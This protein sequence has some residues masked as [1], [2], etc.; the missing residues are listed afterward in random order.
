[1]KTTFTAQ[2]NAASTLNG[3]HAAHNVYSP[4]RRLTLL[5]TLLMTFAL[6]ARAQ[7]YYVFLNGSGYY[8][9]NNNGS[10]RATTTFS[11]SCVWIASGTLGNTSRSLQSY[12]DNSDY[13]RGSTNS[14]SIGNSQSNWR[15]DNDYLR[16]RQSSSNQRYIGYQNNNFTFTSNNS[17]SRDFRAYSVTIT[18]N[19]GSEEI[20]FSVPSVTINPTSADIMVPE[21]VTFTATAT[22]SVTQTTSTQKAY[23]TFR[24]NNKDYLYEGTS[25]EGFGQSLTAAP[26]KATTTKEFALQGYNY[27]LSDNLKSCLEGSSTTNSITYASKNPEE[28]VVTGSITVTPNYGNNEFNVPSATATITVRKKLDNPTGIT[29]EDLTLAVDE[30]KSISY[31]LTPSNAYDNI[32]YSGNYNGIISID[33]NGVVKGLKAGITTVTLTAKNLNGT[34]SAHSA[35]ST[36]TVTPKAPTIEFS[37]GA[38]I[39]ATIS[40]TETGATIYYTTDGTTPTTS[41]PEYTAPVSVTAGATVKAIVVV[42]ANG[43]PLT[44]PVAE[45]LA[46]A[47]SGIV[48][49]TVFLYDLE[50]H[51]WTYYSG[52]DASVDGGNYNTNYAGKLYSPNPRNVKITYNANGGA[53]SIDESETSFVYF[54]T[55]EQGATA[56]QYPYTV[57]S[58]PFSK[59]PTGKGFGGWKIISGG[60]YINGYNNGSTLPLDQE[61]TFVNLPYPSTNCISAEIELEATWVDLNNI[62]RRT[63][64]GDYTY[65]ATGGT[66][67]TNIL[68]LK[69]NHTGTITVNSPCTIMMVEPDGTDNF[70][71]DYT[72]SGYIVPMAN[73]NTKIEFARWRPGYEGINPRGRNFTIGRGM[74]MDGTRR[75][76]YGTDQR[77]AMNQIL[78]V[79]SGNF[80][81]FTS[82]NDNPTSITKHWVVFGCDYDRAKNDNNR[83][84]F[85]GE[86]ITG[87]GRTLGL[88][89]KGEMARVWSK[90][91][92][93]MTGVQ[94]ADAAAD[95]SY[96]VGV[97]TNH[98]NGHRY[99]E[100]QGGEWY[101]NIA[102]GMGEDHTATDPGFTFRMKG[103]IIRGSVYGAAAFAGAGG[104]RTYVITG[105]TIGGWVAGGANGTQSSGGLL[106]GTTYIY[107]GGKARVDSKGS[108]NV[109]NRAVGG[110]VFGAGCG[111]GTGSDSGEIS[112]GTNVVIADEA[113]IERGV[114]GGGSY[115]FTEA[116][117]NL[118]ITGGRIGG[119]AGGV[120]GTSY[121]ANIPGGVYGGACQNRGGTVNIYMTDGEVNGGLYGGSNNSGTI[122]NNVTMKI[123]GGQVGTSSKSA[124]IHGGGY[125]QSTIVTGNVNLSLGTSDQTSEGVTVW[126]DVYGG[127]ALGKVNCTVNNYNNYQYTNNTETNVTLYKGTING[128]LYGGALGGSNVGTHVYGPV[129]VKVY[130]G[131]VKKTSA[132]GSGGVYGAN[133]KDGAPQRSVTV[134]IYG[135]DPAPAE[136]Q[137]ALHAVY[138][139]GNQAP[140]TYGNGYPKVTVHNCDNSIEYVYGGGNAAAVAATDVTIWGGDVIG[141]VFGGGNGT[142]SAADVNGDATTKIYGGTILN[143]YGGSNS[144]GTIGGTINVTVNSQAEN[145]GDA[146]CTMNIGSVYGGGNL[147]ASNVGNL[148]ITCTGT[149]GRIDNV[150]GGANQANITGDID[151]KING[152]NI[153]NVFGGNNIKGDISGTI[154]VTVGDAPNDCG[155]FKVD[156]VY[157][158]GNLAPYGSA[159]GTKG[160]YPVVNIYSGTV[161]NNVFG[162]GLG[163]SAIVYGNPQVTIGD[164]VDEHIAIVGGDVY[165]GGDA[166]NVVG[167]PVVKIINDCNTTI[168]NVYGGGNAADVNGTDVN[169]DG[170]TITGMV[171][172]GGHGDK[173]ADPQTEAN[174]NGDVNVDITGGTINKVFGG[175]NSKGNITGTIALNIEKGDESCEIHIT[176]VYGGGNEAAGNAGTITI[177]CTGSETEGI[178]D[179]YGGANA[180]DINTPI[181][182][183][184]T[185]GNISRVFGGNNTSGSINGDIQVNVDWTE[186]CGVNALGNVYGAGNQAAYSGNTEV[187]ILNG[188]V[189]GSVYG[190]GL[191]ATAVVTG[192][193]TVNID[194]SAE[195][196]SVAV[197]QNVLGGGDAAAVEGSTDVNII[198]GAIS[199]SVFGGGN[200]AGVSENGVVDVTGGT[201][202]S[203]V[204]GGSNASGTVGNTTVALADGIIGTD[205]A[206]ANVH[207]GGYGKETKVSGNVAVNIQGGTIYGDIYGGSALGTVNTNPSNTTAVNL[208]GGLVHGDAYGGGLGDSDTA[209]DVNGNVTVTLDG[210]AFTLATTTDDKGNTIPTSGRVFGCNN[211]NG[212]PKGTVL[213]KVLNTVARDGEGNVKAK[214]TP[215][216]GVYELQ[217]V[218]GGGNL[219][220]YNPTDPAADGQ[221]TSYTYGGNTVA[222]DNID[223]PVQVVIDGCDETSIEYVYG[224]G[225]AAATPATD[226]TVL[227]SYEIGSVFGGGNGK[228]K[229]TLDRGTTWNAN[230]GADVGIINATAYKADNSQGKYGTGDA[231]TS[232]LG[233]TVHNIYGGS[234]TL[235]NIVGDATAYLDAASDCELNIDGIYGGGNEAYMD[236]NSGIQLGCITYLKEIYG[237]ARNADVGGDINLTITSGH[238]DRVFGGNN[239]GGLVKGSITV[240]IEETGCNPITIGELY[241]CGNKAAYTTPGDRHPT[242]NI[243]SF[244]SIGNVFG[245]G[246]GEEAV[247]TGNPTVNINVAKG[248]NNAVEGWPYNGNTI[249]FDDGST[250]TLPVHEEGKIGAIGNVFGGGNAAAVIG[251][252]QVNIG[253]EASVVFE[254]L[255]GAERTKTVEGA[256]IRGNVYGGG[257]QA[258]VTGKTNVV[259][260]R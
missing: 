122:S 133:N 219:A 121:S 233:G 1:M 155:V 91:G 93:F 204:Y 141:N 240:N 24:F 227:G 57:I 251:N 56:G 49:N 230:N 124:N 53:V 86:F 28:E 4:L 258:K 63:N 211:I 70:R 197:T 131:S 139:G 148:I 238:F 11:P 50:D 65:S 29:A 14:L 232:V 95:N 72:F 154:S 17:S 182:L 92:S 61:I 110:N 59:R 18:T 98:N 58:N 123:N 38:N 47:E 75:A 171:F 194:G 32:V 43:T 187:N 216:S 174:V 242:I 99:L 138:G 82:Y 220:A 150:Y 96:Y 173:N 113:Y 163:E 45:A 145:S 52:V 237:G 177:G 143:V 101:A 15:T 129:K 81:T 201:I 80:S 34:N 116:S 73:G 162:G 202:A 195:G 250:V 161:T 26:E 36:V 224:G 151:L 120:N 239:L 256:D 84:T 119:V 83:L 228:D 51:N 7:N 25:D 46:N 85:T 184:I 69:S 207:G 214:P 205:A 125:G 20:S 198:N 188:T 166:A 185:G 89:S 87:E 175:S 156:N 178:G 6:G 126:G 255:T 179:V 112:L 234:N 19:N 192:T 106:D 104:I 210:T 68:V 245:G 259:V 100:I 186:T 158:A 146:P 130:G 77:E 44:S 78:K 108:T 37:L 215:N 90:S 149:D 246:L 13:L 244:T 225:N 260:G 33:A 76:L 160:N 191:G 254:S 140:Y 31:T 5:V 12:I 9:E 115:G 167:I 79:E 181:T 74:V 40:T 249:D 39:T 172:G 223:K 103:G 137:Y 142:V 66:Y 248:A 114:Y 152:G 144:Q 127:S 221:F 252:T 71:D 193:T 253:T 203:G 22:E 10:P 111:N 153:G 64:T 35:T 128:S 189:T 107:V 109:I 229:Y 236:G 257:N 88:S 190:G 147:A 226:V 134:D 183:N 235:G 157:G 118:Y 117:S 200:A 55:L 42:T 60:E 21:D 170:G 62:V 222:H 199:G 30:Q 105:G 102:G 208:T 165:G 132:D 243:R 41:S 54:K 169:I 135:T 97:T 231:M 8:L 213:V 2:H 247:V 48:G 23:T 164:A 218:Y 217:A 206:H 209:A 168:G 27:T 136:N 176:E 94:V 159:S 212:S 241:G 16:Y 196:H 180:A 3:S 67:E